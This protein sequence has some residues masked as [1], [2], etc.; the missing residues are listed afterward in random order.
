MNKCSPKQSRKQKKSRNKKTVLAIRK[1]LKRKILGFTIAELLV[2]ITIIA[3]LSIIALV[4]YP[5]IQRKANISSI[6]NGLHDIS[7][8]LNIFSVTN[9]NLPATMDCGQPNSATNLCVNTNNKEVIKYSTD[10]GQKQYYATIEKN[11]YRYNID[12]NG[13]ILAGPAPVLDSKAENYVSYNGVGNSWNDI[14]TNSV[15]NGGYFNFNNPNDFI[16]SQYPNPSL[17]KIAIA[18]WVKQGSK[19]GTYEIMGQGKWGT[20]FWPN[21]SFSQ[22]GQTMKFNLTDKNATEYQ[23]SGGQFETTEWHYVVGTWD[24]SSMRTYI[25]GVEVASCTNEVAIANAKGT[26]PVGKYAGAS[27]Y[28]NGLTGDIKVYDESMSA[29]EVSENYNISKTYY[30][31]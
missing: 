13:V 7:K 26:H 19:N 20:S 6:Q 27:Y 31:L 10:T 3:I 18:V 9:G 29:F 21:W 16:S 28:F 22:I 30:K 17:D 12:E 14:N 4:T 5:G 2:A 15:Q 8:Q 23:C 11:G 25:N 1:I 24:G